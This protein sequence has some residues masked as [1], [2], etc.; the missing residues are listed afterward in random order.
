MPIKKR[1]PTE[2]QK[3]AFAIA[4]TNGGDLP[5]AMREAGY[6]SSSASLLREA[7]GF[8]ELQNRLGLTDDLVI[9]SLVNDIKKK[10]LRRTKELELASK[11]KGYFQ[12]KTENNINIRPLILPAELMSKNNIEAMPERKQVVGHREYMEKKN[13]QEDNS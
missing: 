12:D 8:K 4:L 10:P 7:E 6:A 2:K 3:R 5:A 13:A 9:G 1:Q 11:I